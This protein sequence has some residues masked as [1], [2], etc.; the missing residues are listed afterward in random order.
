MRR[1]KKD[2]L[3]DL[4]EKQEITIEVDLPPDER[5]LYEAMRRN[6]VDELRNKK[7]NR[8]SILAELTKLRR[9]C[10]HPALVNPELEFA[11]AKMQ[12]IME[13]VRELYSGGH[14]ALIFSQY[15]GFLDLLRK[16]LERED[17]TY[18]YLDGATPSDERLRLVDAFQHGSGDFFLISLKAGG[19]GLNLT[20]ANYV[21]IADPWW[22]P[23]VEDQAAD[24]VYRIGQKN[25]VTVYR[26]VTMGTVEEKV[27]AMHKQKRY[28]AE[29][30]LSGAGQ[31][32]ITS[33][34]LLHLFDE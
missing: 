5:A 11:G 10:C 6:A 15:V 21:I 22:N 28:L 19:V 27:I 18:Q 8:I 4:P 24:R 23:A 25:P 1:M 9:V 3:D 14:R 32:A 26:M 16:E 17:L 31:T 33:E 34:E 20:A 30:V 29:D 2:V 13:L 12:R 7:D